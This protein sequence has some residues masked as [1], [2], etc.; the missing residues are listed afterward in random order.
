MSVTTDNLVGENVYAF[1]LTFGGIVRSSDGSLFIYGSAGNGNSRSFFLRKYGP[2]GDYLK[3]VFPPSPELPADSVA[4]YGVNLLSAGSWSPKTSAIHNPLM[5]SSLLVNGTTQ[6]L[7]IGRPGELVFVNGTDA[8]TLSESGALASSVKRKIITAPAAPGGSYRLCGPGYLVNSANPDYLYLSG[9]YFGLVDMGTWLTNALDTGFWADGQV[10]KVNRSTG[11]VTPFIRLDSIPVS[12]TE[13]AA[14]IGGGANAISTIHGVT[15]DD[16]LHVFVC[17]RLHR[18]ISVYDTNGV[19]IGALPVVNPDL[20]QVSKRTGALYVIT[21]S[22]SAMSLL[23][24]TGWRNPAAATATV[25]LTTSIA[26]HSGAPSLVLTEDGNNTVIWTGYARFGVRQYID[27]GSSLS[28]VRDFST[29]IKNL[30]YDRIAVDR[31]SERTYV[32]DSYSGV[33]KIDNWSNPILARCS[34]SLRQP[35]WAGDMTI[36]PS[37]L[38][39]VRGVNAFDGPIER[40]TQDRLHVPVNYSNTGSNRATNYLFGRYG[41]GWGDK[42]FSVSPQ[43]TIGAIFMK[44]WNDYAYSTYPDTGYSD[45]TFKGVLTVTTL[46][47]KCGG[48]KFDRSGNVYLGMNIKAA[49]RI[50]PPGYESDWGFGMGGAVAKYAPSATGSISGTT[51]V[52]AAFVY[53]Q[54]YG[55][56]SADGGSSC[57]CRSPRFDVDPYGRIFTPHGAASRITVADNAGN[58]IIAF[59][60]Y[61]NTDNRLNESDVPLAWPIA[62]A[63]TEDYIYINDWV[64]SRLARVNMKYALDN[65]PGFMAPVPQEK[66]SVKSLQG[67]SISATPNPFNPVTTIQFFYSSKEKVSLIIYDLKGKMVIDLTQSLSVNGDNFSVKWNGKDK[68]GLAVSTGCYIAVA[69]VGGKRLQ[70]KLNLVR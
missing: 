13:R 36:A 32:T 24:F 56:F 33:W 62:V 7:P 66:H 30:I 21:R 48:V 55:A 4:G 68:T 45:T 58:T 64:N 52:G 5:T 65:M 70:K 18:R 46:G 44:S 19:L 34:T 1:N 8:Q 47:G 28:L 37:G 59:G 26:T 43:G 10:F 22:E 23:K 40:Y 12:K 6:M 17:D 63:A 14:K 50:V 15:I 42:G 11:V 60:K 53:P 39:Y 2:N 25:S 61:G 9:Y 38:L 51:A 27:N 3:T 35:L 29:G 20:V 49:D 41:I 69:T 54:P 57:V 67:H 16:S 31:K